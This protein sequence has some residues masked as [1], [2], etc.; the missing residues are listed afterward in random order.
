MHPL[1]KSTVVSGNT[2]FGIA[3]LQELA[4]DLKPDENLFLSPYSVSQAVL[5]A[6]N[7]S[8]GEM[9]A[10]LLRVLALDTTPLDTING[11]SQSLM[12][13]LVPPVR[14]ENGK[15]A[16]A[17]E[18]TVANAI[19]SKIIPKQDYA[20]GCAR[21]YNADALPFIGASGVNLWANEKTRGAVPQ[22]IDDSLP[23]RVDLLLTNAVYFKGKWVTPFPEHATSDEP[24]YG[25]G[26]TSP[27]RFMH[28]E[29]RQMRWQ[30]GDR[31]EAVSLPY[32]G[33][34]SMIVVLPRS[35]ISA[36]EFVTELS[37]AEWQVIQDGFAPKWVALSLP[38][39]EVEYDIE[40]KKTLE[41]LGMPT[42]GDFSPVA[43]PFRDTG[44]SDVIHKT[45]LRVNEEG[46]EAAAVTAMGIP[47]AAMEDI[48]EKPHPFLVNRPFLCAIVHDA[49]GTVLFL[50]VINDPKVP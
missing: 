12:G 22:I 15:S 2:A 33:G 36:V 38:K 23:D 41:S 6:A 11:D 18:W 28:R 31:Y 29:D 9:Q 1:A 30:T 20:D 32:R 50:G 7:G 42:T 44:I 37:P 45:F 27:K 13:L 26:N 34:I 24:F 21:Y 39:F 19:W 49:T 17:Y 48:K 43:E 10:G 47:G 5:L 14:T 40:L 46:S 4:P 35:G 25:I 3:L 8:Q 16:P